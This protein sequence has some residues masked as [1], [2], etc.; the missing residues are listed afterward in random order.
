MISR[1]FESFNDLSIKYKLFFS[2]LALILIPLGM[3]LIINTFVTEKENEKE[4]LYSAR[5]VLSQTNSFLQFKTES[6]VNSLNVI[7]LNDTVQE[8][9]QKKPEQYSD[10]IGLWIVDS[11]KL[12]KVFVISKGNPDIRNIHLYM[13]EGLASLAQ[14]SDIVDLNQF[15]DSDWYRKLLSDRNTVEW[16]GDSY[17]PQENGESYIHVVRNIPSSQNLHESIGVVQLEIPAKTIE[18]ILDQSIFTKSTTALLINKRNEIISTS[19][20]HIDTS[21]ETY[22]NIQSAFALDNLDSG[23]VKTLNINNE[24]ILVG[25]QNV[26]NTDWTLLLITPYTD[27]QSLSNKSRKPMILVFL[28]IAMITLPLSFLA[29]SSAVKRIKALMVQ[30][31][32]VV[33]GD[34]NVTIIPSSKDEI[35]ELIRNYSYMLT[36]IS[37]NIDEKYLLGKEMK[38]LELR[39][40]QSQINPHFLYNTL[41]LINW[42]SVKNGVPEIGSVVEALSRFYKLSLS[43]GEDMITIKNELEHV[44]V[45]VQIQNMRF[46]EGIQL[47]VNVPDVVLDYC[48]IKIVLQPI[49]EN[50]ILHGILEKEVETGKILIWSENDDRM[51]TLH[52]QDD[53]IGMSDELVSQLLTHMPPSDKR[54][55]Y[56]L[57][58][59]NDRLKLNYGDEYGLAFES[60]LGIGTTVSVRIPLLNGLIPFEV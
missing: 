34:Y 56:G 5:Q 15:K 59:I 6:A 21:L 7:A 60:K 14:N 12:D 58:N 26:K 17:F 46:E 1:W 40:L 19:S 38:N 52:V 33:R 57:K 9:I 27:I 29:A 25:L 47:E 55:G 50:A 44:R 4:V 51:I 39:A 54:L 53:G 11:I 45:Y 43:E 18:L 24:K 36:T 32:K 42:M 13:K 22:H 30:M 49:I 10:N 28:I 41:D 8:L 3:F 37:S 23:L 31:R 48:I 35:G 20:K 2:Y 16:F